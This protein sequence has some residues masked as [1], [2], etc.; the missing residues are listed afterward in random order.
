MVKVLLHVCCAPCATWPYQL[1]VSQGYKPVFYFYN[2]NIHPPFEY[3]RR[4]QEVIRLSKLWK[5]ALVQ[6]DYQPALWF[7]KTKGLWDE[8]EGG[9]RCRICYRMRLEKTCQKAK[10]LG[11][12]IFA[13]TLTVS[14]HIKVE[15]VIQEGKALAEKYGLKFLDIIF[16]KK[17][18][19]QKS[20]EISK[21][22]GL[23]RQNY[24][25][26]IFSLRREK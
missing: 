23:Y 21:K 9:E 16:R 4:L 22:L 7:K 20:V 12:E 24:C 2:P 26:C 10:E 15:W 8:P 18:G 13:T 5:V 11:F 19:F 14:P 17:G 1:L 3:R 6:E 25:G